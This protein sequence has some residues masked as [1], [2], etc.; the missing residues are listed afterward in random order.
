MQIEEIVDLVSD[1]L[2]KVEERLFSLL[3]NARTFIAP[4]SEYVFR[5][6]GKRIRP[7]MLLLVARTLAEAYGKQIDGKLNDKLINLSASAEYLH[8]ATLMHDDVIDGA[9]IRRGKETANKRFGN[10]IVVLCG[11]Y[12]YATAFAEIVRNGDGRIQEVFAN[13]AKD[14]SE[15]E[16]LQLERTGNINLT[17]NEYETIMSGKTAVLFSCCCEIASIVMESSDSERALLKKFGRDF[18]ILFQLKDDFLDY[19][20]KQSDTGKRLGVDLLEGKVTLPMLLLIEKLRS[21]GSDSSKSELSLVQDILFDIHSTDEHLKTVLG[22]ME[23][24]GI[25]QACSEFLDKEHKVFY[26]M[27]DSIPDN[28]YKK[29]L[30]A[31]CEYV[32]NR[33]K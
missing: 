20:G 24:Y 32:I 5:S 2:K 10:D 31:L 23:R 9:V 13:T 18:G 33:E 1:D 6:G 21:V 16:L 28:Q 14:M 15:G 11:D 30:Y 26:S 29:A 22:I 17:Y 27:L 25:E 12:L 19:Y 4:V 3:G 7:L 8:T